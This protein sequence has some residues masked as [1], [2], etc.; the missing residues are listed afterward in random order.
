MS[1]ILWPEGYEVLKQ[2]P[3]Q[4]LDLFYRPLQLVD[5]QLLQDGKKFRAWYSESFYGFTFYFKQAVE[6]GTH[7]W[8]S[9]F[10]D[11]TDLPIVAEVSSERW[12]IFQ[13]MFLS[14]KPCIQGRTRVETPGRQ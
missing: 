3:A 9:M 5:D 2:S 6:D 10:P 14:E 8:A 1:V 11:L 13:K 4:V 12:G 7:M